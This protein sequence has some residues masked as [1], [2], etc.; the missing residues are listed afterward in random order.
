[1]DCI[2][3]V[4]KH[5]VFMAHNV[6]DGLALLKQL[7][8]GKKPQRWYPRMWQQTYQQLNGKRLG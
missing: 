7:S 4:L 1:M 6:K 3:E 8:V 5:K 2:K